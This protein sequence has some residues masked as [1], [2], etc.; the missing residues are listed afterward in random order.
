MKTLADGHAETGG[1]CLVPI[2]ASGLRNGI[3][4]RRSDRESEEGLRFFATSRLVTI[5]FEGR[6]TAGLLE[7]A[8]E[9]KW[10]IMA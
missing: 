5:D 8:S 9:E 4:P 6:C 10:P 7:N 3:D 1:R 2:T